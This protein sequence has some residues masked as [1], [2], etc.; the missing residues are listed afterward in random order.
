VT[1]VSNVVF[2]VCLCSFIVPLW[3]HQN[4]TVFL[5]VCLSVSRFFWKQSIIDF[6]E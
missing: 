6:A 4:T 3:L 2:S 1:K 5:S